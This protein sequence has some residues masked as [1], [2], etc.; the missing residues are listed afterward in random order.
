LSHTI[1]FL[2]RIT[3]Y[4]KHNKGSKTHRLLFI[5]SWWLLSYWV[6]KNEYCRP[7][8]TVFGN[9]PQFGRISKIT[10]ILSLITEWVQFLS[11][12]LIKFILASWMTQFDGWNWKE[13]LKTKVSNFQCLN[14]FWKSH[15]L[16]MDWNN[17]VNLYSWLYYK[18]A[19]PQAK[20]S[21]PNI[22]WNKAS[23][24]IASRI[25]NFFMTLVCL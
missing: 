11:F 14:V 16:P 20:C 10:N 24:K 17:L 22:F 4:T 1:S 5:L 13:R 18:K 15:K 25:Q 8:T 6:V 21:E 3:V 2:L 7:K 12:D 9:W 23:R 19:E